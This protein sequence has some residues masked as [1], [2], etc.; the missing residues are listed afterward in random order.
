MIQNPKIRKA[1]YVVVASVASL[2][3]ALGLL[4]A[5]QVQ[6]I[7]AAVERFSEAVVAL[8]AVMAAR[9]TPAS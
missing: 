8:I 6:D 3:F 1:A 2:L 4:D 5:E 9:N 7:P